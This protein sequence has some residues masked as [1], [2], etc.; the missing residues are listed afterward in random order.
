[1]SDRP[2]VSA[3][4]G[5]YERPDMLAEL[6]ENLRAQTYRPLELCVAME[7]SEDEAINREYRHVVSFGQATDLP[8][9]FVECGRW[10]SGFLANSISA[11]PFQMAQWLSSG[12]YLM[13]AA[14]DERFTATHVEQLV[15]LAERDQ[16]DFVYPQQGCYWRGAIS[17][18][19][20]WI[21]SDP[22]HYGQITHALYRVELLD[23]R[24]FE[25]NVGSG[26]D[27]DQVRSW[28]DAGARWAFLRKQTMTHR[29][30]KAGDGNARLVRQPLRGHTGRTPAE[31][32]AIA[33]RARGMTT[34]CGAC[35]DVTARVCW[36]HASRG[37][38]D[39]RP[40]RC[41]KIGATA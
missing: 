35:G 31:R 33:L 11:V 41:S 29:V 23:Y 2:L 28:M 18:H 6:I 25:I 1:M 10:W 24:G 21:G 20:N 26:T 40:C 22:P 27:W 17:R 37:A 34:D 7:P 4:C 32:E 19:T 14:D 8:I 30:D 39:N 13:W 12:D 38:A 15:E 36:C 16:A 9:K 3:I 5:S